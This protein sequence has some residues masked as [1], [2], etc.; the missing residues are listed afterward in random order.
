MAKQLKEGQYFGSHNSITH[1]N[2][3]IISDTKYT[4]EYVDWHYHENPYFT[5]LIEGQLIEENKKESYTLKQGSLIYHNWQDCHRNIKPPTFTR[6]IHIEVN[7]EWLNKYN[8]SLD[9]VQGSLKIKNPKTKNLVFKLLLE[10]KCSDSYSQT[11]IEMLVTELLASLHSDLKHKN[12][13]KPQWTKRLNELIYESRE[14]RLSLKN[15]SKELNLHHVYLSRAFHSHYG[16]TFGQFCRELRLNKAISS[17][18]SKQHNLTDIAYLSAYYDQS[19]MNSDFRKNF[20]MSPKA[21]TKLL[22]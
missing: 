20:K 15:I 17:I 19:H 22:G 4:H 11:S 14:E 13:N 6:G 1:V 8:I 21:I 16:I 7:R 2:G 3:I 18:L 12:C 9:L 10:S 5:F